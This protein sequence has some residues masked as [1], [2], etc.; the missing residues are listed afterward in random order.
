MPETAVD[1]FA[2]DLSL[3]RPGF[4]LLHCENNVITVR[5]LS[6]V[7]NKYTRRKTHG[8]MLLEIARE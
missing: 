5:E 3:H 7:N 4:A 2:C 6:N 1:V 8:Q